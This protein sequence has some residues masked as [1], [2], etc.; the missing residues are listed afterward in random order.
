[1]SAIGGPNIVEDGLVVA[2]DAAN[3][4]SFRGEP[5][6]NLA[7]TESARTMIL[8][9]SGASVSLQ[10]APERGIG[11][12]KV[13]ITARGSNFR[14]TRFPYI[15]HP[16]NTTRT[17][18]LEVDFGTTV[19]YFLRGDGFTGFGTA[20]SSNG[21]IAFTFTTTTNSGSLAVFLNH[22]TTAI[23][24]INDV[25]YYRYYQVE[26]KPYATPFVNGT[27]GTTVATGGGWADRSVN[28]NHGELV[29]GPTF[30]SG[31][32]GSIVFD[33]VDD[34]ISTN[35]SFNT[36]QFTYETWLSSSNISKDQMYVGSSVDAF[37]I[38][39]VGSKA[40]L[41]VSANGQR[42]LT[43]SQTLQ[44][45]KIYQIVSVYNGVQ[46]KIYVNG[47]LTN[48]SVINQVMTRWGGNRIGRWRD[49]DQRSF[50][51]SVFLMNA[52][53]RELTSTEILQNYNAIKGR[54]GL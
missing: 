9:D 20:Q 4:K 26:D 47:E 17:Y 35:Q 46:L 5:T 6:V 30:S 34:Y 37:Y 1:M 7:G 27:R 43:H 29:N 13:I 2:L 54:F 38:R 16:T 22:N 42:T 45:N 23:S 21:L 11:W 14:V 19:G 12:K 40:F 15:T 32:L 52:Y 24:G 3:E 53:D 31:N 41:S 28:S 33:G 48:G 50:V 51:G 39:I 25:I 44:N 49:N 10:D 8:H 18:S 36:N